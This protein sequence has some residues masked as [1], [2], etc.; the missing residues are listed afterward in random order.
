MIRKF[1][2]GPWA[3]TAMDPIFCSNSLCKK[4]M[5]PSDDRPPNGWAVVHVFRYSHLRMKSRNLFLCPDCSVVPTSRQA[6]LIPG[7]ETRK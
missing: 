7:T 1:G 4:P 5:P 3:V 2:E 6:T